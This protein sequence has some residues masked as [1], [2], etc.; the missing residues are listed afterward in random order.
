MLHG[1]ESLPVRWDPV[2]LVTLRQPLPAAADRGL[3]R[4]QPHR[5]HGP[6]HGH[7]GRGPDRLPRGARPRRHRAR[8]SSR[9]PAS[10]RARRRRSRCTATRCCPFYER[11]RRPAARPRHAGV[12]AALARRRG[13]RP[14]RPTDLGQRRARRRRSTSIPRAD[15][16]GDDRRHRRRVRRAPPARCRDGGLDGVELHGAH[17]YLDRRSSCRRP[18]TCATTTTAARPRAGPASSSRSS[19]A[20]RAEVGPD[21]PVGVRLSGTDFIE[22]GID[23][24]EAAAIAR[25]SSRWS[26]SSTCRC[27][28][29][30]GST[31]SCRRMDD[32][33]GYEIP[34]SE[35]VTKAVGVPDHR[36]RADHDP[37]P[38]RATSSRPASPTWCRWCGR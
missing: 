25:S 17:G 35:Q 2:A 31:S 7:G 16:E 23:P 13:L 10:S 3:H 4:P 11:A 33:L 5:P 9:S 12:P 24:V 1:F 27:R 30:G 32:P 19:Q 18:P 29:T 36:D 22:G 38:R 6:L 20:I 26:T 28:R 37:R 8:P 15:D 34:T 21:F 14:G